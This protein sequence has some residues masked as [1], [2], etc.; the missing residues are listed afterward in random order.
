[1]KIKFIRFSIILF[2]TFGFTNIPAQDAQNYSSETEKVVKV[3]VRAF[4]GVDKATNR[5]S[6]TIDYLSSPISS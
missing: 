5:W 3:A 2:L 1:M 4:S 6:A